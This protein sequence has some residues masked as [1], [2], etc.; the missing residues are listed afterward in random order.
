MIPAEATSLRI[1]VQF[2]MPVPDVTFIPAETTVK[3]TAAP[4]GNAEAKAETAS[5]D[6][7]AN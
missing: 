5:A 3:I 1:K 6:T 2:D 4:K 7:P